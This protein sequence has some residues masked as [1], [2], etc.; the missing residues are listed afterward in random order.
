MSFSHA[1]VLFLSLSLTVCVSVSVC[2]CRCLSTPSP[3]PILL[4]LLLANSRARLPNHIALAVARKSLAEASVASAAMKT[5]L[6]PST[7]VKV[8]GHKRTLAPAADST[9]VSGR[10][11]E[12]GGGGGS[13][14]STK[15]V[16]D[17][18][19]AMFWRLR[20]CCSSRLSPVVTKLCH[21]DR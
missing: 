10:G 3:P 2:D 8:K 21:F 20:G 6:G 19:G 16:E 7:R 11:K 15:V 13:G 12:G 9:G 1:V 5:D 4:L 18:V 17:E 14:R